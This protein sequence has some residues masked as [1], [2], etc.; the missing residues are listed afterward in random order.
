[1]VRGSLQSEVD[2][3]HRDGGFV[4]VSAEARVGR[5]RTGADAG[6]ADLKTGKPV[7]HHGHFRAGSVT[8]G[9]VATV[10]LQLEA[11]GRLSLDDSVEH[12]LPGLI[13]GNGN[14]GRAITL[15]NLLQHTS[16]LANYSIVK[17]F[18]Q[19]ATAFERERWRHYEPEELVAIAVEHPPS[20]PPA[21]KDDP[22]PDWEY[23][24]TNYIVAGMVIE[25]VTGRNW[26][27]E[28]R[29]RVLAPLGLRDT[30]APGDSPW[31]PRP[32]ARTYKRF[33]EHRDVWTDTTLRNM[34][35]GG[36]A[37]ELISTERDLDRF[38]TALL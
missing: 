5:H 12:S 7:P 32:H 34:S 4:S 22:N 11:E 16:G 1:G 35:F 31:L 15:R 19:T 18:D 37:A 27:V 10:L 20:F 2:R 24:N 8:K 33:P 17:D 38:M 13:S 25:K 3:T 36:A 9:F 21:D 29:D 28:L 6:V 14:D 23:S 30:F 26:R